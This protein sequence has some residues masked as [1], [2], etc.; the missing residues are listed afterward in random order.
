[1]KK[2]GKAW[3]RLIRNYIQSVIKHMNRY[4]ISLVRK[5]LTNTKIRQQTH[6]MVSFKNTGNIKY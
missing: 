1:M 2:W 3:N 4:T 5:M 6:R